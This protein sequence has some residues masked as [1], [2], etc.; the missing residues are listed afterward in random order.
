ADRRPF[1][2]MKLVQGR[3]LAELLG[4][5][6]DPRHDEAHFLTI[7]EQVCQTLAYAHAR[8]VIHRDLKPANVM[9]GSFGEVQ[10]M[11]WGLANVLP[12]GP[13]G[14]GGEAGPAIQTLRSAPAPAQQSQA[15]MLLGTLGFM[16]PEQARG[17][18]GQ[19]DER[20]DVFGLGAI[21]C[22]LLT[23][24]P[25]FTS[26]STSALLHQSQRG[27]LREATA[28]LAGCGADGELVQLCQACLAARREDRPRHAGEV[29]AGLA[30]YRAAVQ[31]RLRQAELQRAAAEARAVEEGKRRRVT[32]LLAAAVLGLVLLGGG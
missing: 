26:S 24:Q 27:E 30:A 8:G 11:D 17:E 12:P 19:V 7:F 18:L 14:A 9:V 32:V 23:G 5:R 29:A 1:F 25:P 16:A 31:Q 6:T 13:A 3:T 4:Q 21:L 22:E 10:V 20:A 28:R 15:G 2:T